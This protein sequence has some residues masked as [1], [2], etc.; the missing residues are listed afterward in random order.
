[1]KSKDRTPTGKLKSPTRPAH[2]I[3]W[4]FGG[5]LLLLASSLSALAESAKL[6]EPASYNAVGWLVVSGAALLAALNQGDDFIARRKGKPPTGELQ[7]ASDAITLRVRKLEENYS[8]IREELAATRETIIS[9]GDDRRM[10][11]DTKL[12][13][14]RLETKA[15]LKSLE[16]KLERTV[17]VINQANESRALE[18]HKRTNAILE[19]V[20][21]IEGR[22]ETT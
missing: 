22:I 13:R 15:D 20:S 14:L 4:A 10:S 11:I 5:L 16:D 17:T 1:M 8:S 21:K 3:S 19:A 18:L 9:E 6:P 2:G 12:D 7:I